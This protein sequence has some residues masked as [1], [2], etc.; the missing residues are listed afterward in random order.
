VNGVW[1]AH[2]NTGAAHG[3]G[4]AVLRQGEILGGD[5]Y[6]S[7]SGTYEEEGSRLYAR[8]RVQ[9]N[10]ID[11]EPA[12]GEKPFMLTFSGSHSGL[13]A[14]LTGRADENQTAVDI[15]LHKAV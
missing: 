11:Q 1:I 9:R 13:D 3:S 8:V 12:G 5:F 6:H 14:A 2:F 10:L 7:W 15:E 4:I